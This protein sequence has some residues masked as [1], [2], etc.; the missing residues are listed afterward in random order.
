MSSVYSKIMQ[1]E[2]DMTIYKKQ[3]TD[4][5]GRKDFWMTIVDGM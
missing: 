1:N 4:A 5:D 2:N 3:A